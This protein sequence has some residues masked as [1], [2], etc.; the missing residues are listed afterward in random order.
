[1]QVPPEGSKARYFLDTEFYDLPAEGFAVELISL[2]LV[3]EDNREFYGV[4]QDFDEENCPH[5]WLQDHVIPK[6]P[7]QSDRISIQE[8]RQ[9]VLDMIEPAETVE[10]WAKN[11]AYDDFILCRLFGGMGP[12][13]RILEAEKGVKNLVFRDTNELRRIFG[14]SS[15]PAMPEQEKHDALLDARHEKQEFED[16]QKKAALNKRRPSP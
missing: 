2:A 6:L 13:R 1:M 12:L 15:V 4:N 8:I 5:Q 11:G 14:E 16:W 7:P 9:G 3:S 10:I